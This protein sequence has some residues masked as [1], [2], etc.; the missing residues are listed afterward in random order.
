M[1]HEPF[2]TPMARRTIWPRWVL[3]VILAI[4]V[5]V[6]WGVAAGMV[7]SQLEANSGVDG[8]ESLSV[9][10]D[11]EPVI[12]AYSTAGGVY[13]D[14]P[15]RDLDRRILPGPKQVPLA[16]A[17]LAAGPDQRRWFNGPVTWPERLIG[18]VDHDSI[19]LA[20]W[21][22][23]HDGLQEGR[24]YLQGFDEQSRL[25]VGYIG[26]DGFRLSPPAPAQQFEVGPPLT[27]GRSHAVVTGDHSQFG[28]E[29][30][31]NDVSRLCVYVL[32]RQKILEIN[33]RDRTVKEL[34]AHADLRSIAIAT[35][36]QTGDDRPPIAN[37]L[38]ARL[39][40]RLVALN[41][42]NGEKVEYVL[43]EKFR[44]AKSLTAYLVDPQQILIQSW[45]KDGHMGSRPVTLVWVDAAGEITKERTVELAGFQ[46]QSDR[47]MAAWFTLGIPSPLAFA[48]MTLLLAPLGSLATHGLAGYQEAVQKIFVAAWPVGLVLLV[49]CLIAA[50]LVVRWQRQYDRSHTAL[51]AVTV[52]VLGVPG[53][54][55]YMIYYGFPRRV[56]CPACGQ[57]TPQRRDACAAC[58]AP[59]PAP[60]L[61][62]T[63]VFA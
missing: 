45:E 46:P 29:G 53:L 4:G 43:P 3:L 44:S 63:E 40:D 6:V 52:F 15:P 41:P 16:P 33:L 21:F 37:R 48:A 38:V 51:W 1:N 58:R 57:P 28:M 47:E 49:A 22:L 50:W 56:P 17:Q 8:Y 26:R 39:P 35:Q 13:R 11:G 25:T 55:A 62:G 34:Y 10:A 31:V 42:A 2:A 32:D 18:L 9:R 61:K 7:I 30:N 36:P 12:D 54:L 24:V 14:L 23:I 59:F 5:A 60:A 27:Y 20:Q 19:E